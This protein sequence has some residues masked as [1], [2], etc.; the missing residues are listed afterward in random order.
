MKN[1]RHI[2]KL[3]MKDQNPSKTADNISLKQRFLI[4]SN[5]FNQSQVFNA[6][7]SQFENGMN[8]DRALEMKGRNKV[9]SGIGSTSAG[10]DIVSNVDGR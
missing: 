10:H 9:Y 8:C 3:S 1:Y 7:Q 5:S 4:A 6:D 2:S